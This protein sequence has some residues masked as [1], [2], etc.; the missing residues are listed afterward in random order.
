VFGIALTQ[1]QDL[2]HGLV[3][4]HEVR[5]GPPLKPVFWMSSLPSSVSH[6]TQLGIAG[7]LAEDALDPTVHVTDKDVIQH[8]SQYRAPR[9]TIVRLISHLHMQHAKKRAM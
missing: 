3:E 6:A 8:C 4:L 1:V 2:A 7:K 5:T 9:N